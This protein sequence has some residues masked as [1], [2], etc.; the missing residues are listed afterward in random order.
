M[1]KPAPVQH[2]IAPLLVER[3][4]PRAFEPVPLPHATLLALLEAAR[5]SPSGGNS[6]PWRFLVAPREDEAL[7]A[8][9]LACLDE[10]NQWWAK[11]ASVLLLTV[12]S[13]KHPRTGAPVKTA[14]YDLGQSI[15][16]LTFQAE[17][18]GLRVHQMGGIDAAKIRTEFAVPE[19]FVP[20]TAV[21]IGTYGDPDALADSQKQQELD[22]VRVRKPLAETCFAGDWGRP[23]AE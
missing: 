4:S 11:R 12:A 7:F 10:K 8:R 6:Q 23:I 15:A 14:P 22:P 5:W 17:S 18:M 2:P 21:A 16:H 1:H 13:L 19:G 20:F 9:A 3:W